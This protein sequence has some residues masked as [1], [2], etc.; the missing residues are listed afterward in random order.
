MITRFA[1]N[2]LAKE[3][4]SSVYF[5]HG[6]AT[7][8]E[9]PDNTFDGYWSVQTLQHIPDLRKALFEAKRVL[10]PSGVFSDYSL[11]NCFFS[12]LIFLIFGNKYVV[13]GMVENSFFL[14]RLTDDTLKIYDEFF[15][16]QTEIRYTEIV[17]KPELR[18]TISG[19]HDSF[20][21]KIDSM[22]SNSGGALRLF[23]RQRSIHAVVS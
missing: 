17:F 7:S 10:R 16:T 22:L 6:D 19:R 11:N 20:L 4:G 9:F 23:A 14:R 12:R 18:F 1:R 2:V 21:G 3:S 15:S 5:V 8:L 13:E